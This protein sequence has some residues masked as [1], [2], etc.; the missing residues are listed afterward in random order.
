MD[1][2]GMVMEL[3]EHVHLG[4][5]NCPVNLDTVDLIVSWGIFLVVIFPYDSESHFYINKAI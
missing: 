1:M 2:N 4:K 3:E 5:D